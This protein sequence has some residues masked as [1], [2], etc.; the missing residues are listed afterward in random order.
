[1]KTVLMICMAL[2]LAGGTM[3]PA[4]EDYNGDGTD[5]IAIFRASSGL[6]AVRGVSR[7]YFGG[8]GDMPYPADY[9]GNGTDSAAI[10][11]AASG[12][13]AVR[14]VTRV[15]FGSGSDEPKPGD[16]NGDG[17]DEVCI[18]RR[19]SGLWAVKGLT[20]VYFGTSGDAALPVG[21]Q[22][23]Q[24]VTG[25]TTEYRA[26]DDGHYQAGSAFNFQQLSIGGDSVTIDHNT[27]LMWAADGDE[28]GCN[29]GN[30]TEWETAIDWCN[31]LDFA[32]Y[33][34]WRLPNIKELQAI[35]NYGTNSPAIDTI[36]FVNTE[37]GGN[38]WS[39]TTVDINISLAWYVNF[40]NGNVSSYYKTPSTYYVRAV[41]GGL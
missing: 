1:M 2:V 34:D 37:Y 38:Y 14:G 22:C 26:G 40:L 13:W 28:E 21:K 30:Q 8:I 16:Y 23:R 33:T 20:R 17:S 25:Q 41:R 18:F 32:G 11:R 36:Y 3:A 24:T 19:D 12:L 5:D 31:N 6:W 4:A 15:Y 27:G 35:V 39:S 10:F 9:N 29:W 7:F